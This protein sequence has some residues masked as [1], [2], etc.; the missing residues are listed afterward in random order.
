[1]FLMLILRIWFFK[2]VT[3]KYIPCLKSIFS[4]LVFLNF[5]LMLILKIG[6]F[7]DTLPLVYLFLS[8]TETV[9]INESR[10][11][12]CPY[13]RFDVPNRKLGPESISKLRS[14]MTR[15]SVVLRGESEE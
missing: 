14:K 10:N 7:I 9:K 13:L 4:L 8:Y 15:F 3:V 12:E 5:C 2:V 6:F 11:N 1:M